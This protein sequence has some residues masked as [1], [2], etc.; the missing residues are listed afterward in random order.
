M[1]LFSRIKSWLISKQRS[2]NCTSSLLEKRMRQLN[3]RPNSRTMNLKGHS[4]IHS[5]LSD[6]WKVKNSSKT[7]I[8]SLTTDATDFVSRPA[9]MLF[10]R[11]KRKEWIWEW[12]KEDGHR[13]KYP[14]LLTISNGKIW[15]SLKKKREQ[16]KYYNLIIILILF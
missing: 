1:Y 12:S 9:P 3:K 4:S 13:S 15:V 10:V 11:N 5:S 7:P 6:Q 2:A 16:G 8:M 14:L